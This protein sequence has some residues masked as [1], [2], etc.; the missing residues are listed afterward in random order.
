MMNNG[1]FLIGINAFKGRAL[2]KEST[3][4][5]VMPDGKIVNEWDFNEIIAAHIRQH[6][7]DKYWYNAFKSLQNVALS[8]LI[9][10]NG[11]H[12]LPLIQ[13]ENSSERLIFNN[14]LMNRAAYRLNTDKE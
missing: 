7:E 3:L 9:A 14:S 2:K 13:K 12:S 4:L 5:E 8:S 1:H 6:G 10:P 11:Q